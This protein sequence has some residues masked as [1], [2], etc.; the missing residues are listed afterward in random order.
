MSRH[1]L[2]A[3]VEVVCARPLLCRKDLARRYG[4]DL[5]TIDRWHA[6]GKLP[7]AIYLPGCR[8]PYWRPVDIHTYEKRNRKLV[9]VEK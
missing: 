1:D 2:A 6:K 7:K 9:P 4:R 3:L 8:F 5:D